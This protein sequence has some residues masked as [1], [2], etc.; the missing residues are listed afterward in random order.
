VGVNLL[1]FLRPQFNRYNKVFEG[2]GLSYG[3]LP[4]E[5]N[6][7][8]STWSEFYKTQVDCQSGNLRQR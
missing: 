2:L 4:R 3:V 5:K 6:H 8:R 1:V 7:S